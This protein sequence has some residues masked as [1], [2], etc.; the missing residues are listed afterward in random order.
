[1]SR[2]LLQIEYDG[3]LYHGWQIQQNVRTIQ[4]EIERALTQL[5][6]QQIRIT[7]SGRTDAGVHAYKQMAHF[8]EEKRQFGIEVYIRGLNSYLPDDIIIKNCHEVPPDF[9]A[10]FDAR[11]RY[12]QY[13]ISL[14]SLAIGRQYSWQVFRE[15]DGE[16]LQ[17][18]ASFIEGTH[19]FLSFQ[20][21]Q[22]EIENTVCKILNSAWKIDGNN[23]R[24]LI[25][26]DRF[27][28][29]MVR[30]LVGTMIEV[31]RNRFTL[32]EFRSFIEQPDKLAPVVRAPAHGLFLS[33]VQYENNFVPS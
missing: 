33:D 30:C 10:R 9:H 12:Y 16:K 31:A 23:L 29:N 17:Q 24:Y 13:Q 26:G 1:M 20:H 11:K 32:K 7:G 6:Q 14:D 22:S 25:C 3:T 18:A 28:H 15:I 2:Y 27:L 5:T 4:E 8:D 19:D 21:A